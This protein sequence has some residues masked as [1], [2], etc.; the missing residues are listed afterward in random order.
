MSIWDHK[1]KKRLRQYPKYHSPVPS[2]AFNSDGTKLAVG[3]S[4][5]WDEGEEGAK[6]AERPSVFIRTTGD[7]VKVR[8]S[9]FLVVKLGSDNAVLAQ[10]MDGE[11]DL[12]RRLYHTLPSVFIS[13]F[14]TTLKMPQ[15]SARHPCGITIVRCVSRRR[16]ILTICIGVDLL[17][18]STFA[19]SVL[20]GVL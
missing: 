2:I 18:A 17:H 5:T 3:V 19:S 10:G 4:Y 14:Q 11:L 9:S 20:E 16:S 7:E 13:P 1:Q 12:S 8:F 15:L 6:T